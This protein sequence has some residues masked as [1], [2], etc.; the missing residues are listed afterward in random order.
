MLRISESQVFSLELYRGGKRGAILE[1]RRQSASRSHAR[2]GAVA[3]TD[4][5]RLVGYSETGP[6]RRS[7]KLASA[8]PEDR[9]PEVGIPPG[10]KHAI[11]P[12]NCTDSR[13]STQR[14]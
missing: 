5:G 2:H 10:T 4:S 12:A 1:H 8:P 6:K 3:E 9:Y 7:G 14:G 11:C 13:S